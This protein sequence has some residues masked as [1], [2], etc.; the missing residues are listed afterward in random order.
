MTEEQ[1]A[2]RRYR[3][4]KRWKT[5]RHDIHVKYHGID[6]I[7]KKKLLKGSECHHLC[8]DESKYQELDENMYIPLN[9]TTHK[10][11]HWAYMYYSKDPDFINRLKYWLDRMVEINK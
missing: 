4:S 8:L 6:P 10:M 7:T 5:W 2:K 1:R 11:V 9:K 3:Q